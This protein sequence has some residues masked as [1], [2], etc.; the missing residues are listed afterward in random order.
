[1]LF[2]TSVSFDISVLELF[3]ALV[4][5]GTLVV[6]K[7]GGELDSSY[8]AGLIRRQSVNFVFTV[9]AQLQLLLNEA[10]YLQCRSLKA[11]ICG[12][13]ALKPELLKAFREVSQ[14]TLYNCYGPTEASIASTSCNC[15]DWRE[16]AIPIG[17]PIANTRCHILDQHG[18]PVAPGVEGELYIG[19]AG[20][21]RGYLHNAELTREKF[22]DCPFIP[23]ER[24]YRTG[25]LASYRR[26][27][28]IDFHGR[29]DQQVKLRGFR[30]ETGEIETV[31]NR[32]HGINEVL[33]T[34][35]AK[36][37]VDQYL[38][39]YYTAAQP[40]AEQQI[41]NHLRA[42]LPDY[43]V[44]AYYVP[45][46]T[47]PRT[48]NGKI[49]RQALP[50]PSPLNESDPG[51]KAETEIE[52]ALALIWQDV[53]GLDSVGIEDNFFELGGH[54]LLLT[55][56]AARI[57]KLLDVEIPVTELFHSPT[58]QTLAAAISQGD[59][60]NMDPLTPVADRQN[61]PAS[62]SQ[63]RL[64]FLNSWQHRDSYNI[65][66]H[67]RLSGDLRPDLLR[68]SLDLMLARHA[69]LRTGFVQL[70]GL[71]SQEIKPASACPFE[72]RD[73]DEQGLEDALHKLA[74]RSS[75]WSNLR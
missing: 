38:V 28:L 12:G 13:E 73:I 7:P 32:L 43:M 70:Q 18:N 37:P 58:I 49:D 55:Q 20:L 25:D 26:D 31:L 67:Y 68:Q 44:P 5:G 75:T 54:S 50:T 8:L 46:D 3:A 10:D 14:A 59:F 19:G 41:R 35:W 22:I 17:R 63:E 42:L 33:V 36:S 30:I 60:A 65:H 9:P 51:R 61:I 34:I 15:S 66:W 45:L 21:A 40:V 53:L 64:W 11:H 4:T 74:V 56:I 24:L 23:G 57:R 52:S 71:L 62:F 72:F 29:A 1:M 47:M 48:P 6:A 27:G 2:H 39:A 16:G 69:S